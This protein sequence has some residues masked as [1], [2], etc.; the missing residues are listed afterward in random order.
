MKKLVALLIL[1]FAFA[2]TES[3]VIPQSKPAQKATKS[4]A[5]A[6]IATGTIWKFEDYEINVD[7]LN[8]Y[9]NQPVNKDDF[10]AQY[11]SCLTGNVHLH[12]DDYQTAHLV[13]GNCPT[14]ISTHSNTALS[15]WIYYETYPYGGQQIMYLVE[16]GLFRMTRILGQS[17]NF[18]TR[19]YMLDYY[20]NDTLMVWTYQDGNAI[21]K[22]YWRRIQ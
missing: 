3:T 1:T 5:N 17:F 18:E 19:S 13:N 10:E 11:S 8:L 16:N 20:E 21:K 15:H 7:F 4:R 2:C 12:F 6:R 14:Y 9:G 22:V